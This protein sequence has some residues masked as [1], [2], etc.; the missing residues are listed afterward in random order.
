MEKYIKF[1]DL[2]QEEKRKLWH[3]YNK[4]A[5]LEKEK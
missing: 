2:P 1:R 4:Q 5:A 3:Y